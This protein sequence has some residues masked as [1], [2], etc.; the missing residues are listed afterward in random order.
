MSE[1][2]VNKVTPRSGTTVTLGD[3]GDTI[4]IPS[5]VTLSGFGANTPAF[6]AVRTTNQSIAGSNTLTT[7]TYSS[8]VYDTDSAFD[9]STGI[10]TAPSAGKYFFSA[11]VKSASAF[12]GVEDGEIFLEGST[13]NNTTSLRLV[14]ANTRLVGTVS[15]FMN[16]SINDTMKVTFQHNTIGAKNVEIA[17][18]GGF[19]LI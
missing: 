10:F 5:G 16:M 11:G 9:E 7:I 8:E 4:T 15:I 18:F 6:L 12:A 17:R 1:L 14:Q 13:S 3:S 2:K 19:K